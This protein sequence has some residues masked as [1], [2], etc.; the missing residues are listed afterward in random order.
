MSHLFT[1]KNITSNSLAPTPGF[2]YSIGYIDDPNNVSSTSTAYA[3]SR[4]STNTEHTVA[5]EIAHNIG[6]TDTKGAS[7]PCCSPNRYVMC[8]GTTIPNPRFCQDTKDQIASFLSSR[9]N[10]LG[11]VTASEYPSGSV[12]I[13][14]SP[15]ITVINT[16]V[17]SGAYLY[18]D[19][20]SCGGSVIIQPGTV[21]QSGATFIVR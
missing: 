1:N 3:L 6:A 5:H 13:I 18:L 9:I 21:I 2:T 8:D 15:S 10:Y 7:T 12:T 17:K 19:A 20:K 4:K 16:E 11:Y 14:H